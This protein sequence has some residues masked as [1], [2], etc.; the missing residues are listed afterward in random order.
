MSELPL[1]S[2]VFSIA[3]VGRTP[4]ADITFGS[5]LSDE[6]VKC[7]H[8]TEVYATIECLEKAFSYIIFLR[9]N[10]SVAL[11]CNLLFNLLF[12]LN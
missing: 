11:T 1:R 3:Q 7:S 12:T 2:I 8:N 4:F 9:F 10:L 6:E 5:A